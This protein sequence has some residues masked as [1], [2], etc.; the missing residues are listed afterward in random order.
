[1]SNGG[2]AEFVVGKVEYQIGGRR[3]GPLPVHAV[4]LAKALIL[5]RDNGVLHIQRDIV[6][7][8]PDAVGAFHPLG[9]LPLAGGDVL[10]IDPGCSRSG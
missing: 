10:R 2:T 8:G 6:Q 7:V 4:V 5:D 9:F 1:M 3:K